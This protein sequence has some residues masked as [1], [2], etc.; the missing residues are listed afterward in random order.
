MSSLVSNQGTK[1]VEL[2]DENQRWSIDRR[3]AMRRVL[4]SK[5]TILRL[6]RAIRRKE[7]DDICLQDGDEVFDVIYKHYS[8]YLPDPKLYDNFCGDSIAVRRHEV[9]WCDPYFGGFVFCQ[10]VAHL[11]VYDNRFKTTW[12]LEPLSWWLCRYWSFTRGEREGYRRRINKLM[13]LSMERNWNWVY[14]C[15]SKQLQPFYRL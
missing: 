14:T 2:A 10:N 7:Y 3:P 11:V 13:I 9:L 4:P 8:L 5:V 1:D 15:V 6:P 12:C